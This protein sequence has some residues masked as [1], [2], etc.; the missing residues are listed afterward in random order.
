[1]LNQNSINN[2][3]LCKCMVTSVI[4]K[5]FL[6]AYNA[7]YGTSYSAEQFFLEVFYP[8]FFNSNKYLYWVQNSPF[9]QMKKGQKVEKLT[10]DERKEKLDNFIEKINS[11][12]SDASIAIGYPASEE[13]EFWTGF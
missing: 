10:P 5:I 11:G 13:K 3:K 6:D 8:L 7:R 9:V 12:V 1:M 4:G 2:L